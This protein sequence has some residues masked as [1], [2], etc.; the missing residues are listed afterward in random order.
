MGRLGIS[1]YPEHSTL[2]Q[3][4]AYIKKAAECGF[5]RIFTCLISA[6]GDVA[7]IKK[8][9][10]E[11]NEYAKKHGMEVIFDIAPPVFDKFNVPH[12]DLTPFY[13][14][15]ANGIRLDE[16]LPAPEEAMLTYNPYGLKV[17]INAS[18]ATRHIDYLLSYGANPDRIISCHNFYPQKFTALSL[19]HFKK[20][21]AIMKENNVPVATF[22]TSHNTDTF[23]PWPVNEGLCTLEMHRELPI[24][25]QA[26]HLIAMGDT[27]DIIIGNCYATDAE[28]EALSQLKD[29]KLTFTL[30][31]ND[32][33]TEVEKEI[34]YDFPHFVRGDMGDYMA[35]STFSRITYANHT[36]KPHDT[37]DLKRGD[38]VILNEEY[39]RYKG[40]L[41]I[42]LEDM[43]NDGNKN[44]VGTL[45][46]EEHI[47]LDY[48]N[49][50]RP[51]KFVR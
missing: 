51:F 42:V 46:I 20:C 25:L 6:E 44:V 19:S 43:K 34:I 49:P 14:M 22:I 27:N 38:V 1:L 48:L 36:I 28:L 5:Q 4:M 47:L 12:S 13:E 41:H 2:E 17:E 37:R 29:G 11:T 3:D 15:G 39:G 23:G 8:R 31:L 24:S 45:P 16:D 33:I 21:N 30:N 10:K 26:R 40:E 9:Y 32:D 50:W 18:Q 35:R 7:D